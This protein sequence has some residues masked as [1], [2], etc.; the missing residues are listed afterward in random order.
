M[1]CTY[2]DSGNIKQVYD[3]F[4]QN[5][6]F[7]LIPF[8]YFQKGTLE[9]SD[10][11]PEFTLICKKKDNNK[12]IAALI[13]IIRSTSLGKVCFLKA[14]L[15]DK[16]FQRKG[17]GTDLLNELIS[18]VSF[19]GVNIISYGDSVPN[20]W[21]P[22]VDLR[23]T[24]LYFFLK[25]NKFRTRKM[26]QNLTVNLENMKIH[27]RKHYREYSFERIGDSDFQNLF[28][29]VKRTFPEGRWAE[30]VALSFNSEPPTSFTAK[31]AQNKIIGWASHSHLFPGSFGP[32][33]V[34][35]SQRGKGIGTELLKWALWDMKQNNITKATIMWV[36]GDTIKYYSK[37]VG[38]H[39]FPVYIPMTRKIS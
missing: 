11:D 16:T 4:K 10:F 32:T 14:C 28:N 25:K 17:I 30:E 33:G 26:R 29:F 20:Y 24:S 22:G 21:Q 9:D 13:A 27:P 39:I 6:V 36:D 15:V 7:S 12:I 1:D 23:H 34:L 8:E 5:R 35:L 18:R 19:K 31:D 37:V 3:L 2:L 38:A